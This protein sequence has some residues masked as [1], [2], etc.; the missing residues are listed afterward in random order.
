MIR[1]PPRSKRTDTLCPY[2]TLF[3]S[4]ADRIFA[5]RRGDRIKAQGREDIPGRRLA[6]ILVARIAVG[7]RRIELSHDIADMMLRLP[8]RTRPIIE[9]W[10]MLDRLVAVRVMPH[11]DDLHLADLV[12]HLAVIAF[13]EDRRRGAVRVEALD[14]FIAPAQQIHQPLTV[15]LHRP[16]L[17]EPVAPG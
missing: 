1:R 12:N 7:R 2:T 8:R 13:V 6:I 3:R 16:A 5:R 10:H 14:E 15:L 11:V 17:M 9:I 4:A